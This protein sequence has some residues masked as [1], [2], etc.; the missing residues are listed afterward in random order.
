M[1]HLTSLITQINLIEFLLKKHPEII[2]RAPVQ[3]IASYLD[4]DKATLSRL[5]AKK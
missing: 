2:Q 1:L 3:Y 4:I 5:R